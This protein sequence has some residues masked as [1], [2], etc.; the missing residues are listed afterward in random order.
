[1]AA[2]TERTKADARV[3]EQRARFRL[4]HKGNAMAAGD[5]LLRQ[6]F[7]RA[8]VTVERRRDNRVVAH[9]SSPTRTSV[10]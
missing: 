7:Q 8:D 2:F 6:R 4:L 10:A 9:P 5:Q 3:A 1:M